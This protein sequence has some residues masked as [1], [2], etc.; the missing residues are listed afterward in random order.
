VESSD[1]NPAHRY[2]ER[3]KHSYESVRRGARRLD[4]TNQPV[5]YKEYPGIELEPLPPHLE[6]LLR[7]GA[8]VVR[9]RRGYEFRTYSS[10]GALYPI[11]VYVAT[12]DG[13]FHFDPRELGV[14]RLRDDD[15][16]ESL[17]GGETV[18][19]LTGILWRTAWKYDARGYRHLFWDAGTM[20]ANLLELAPADARVLTGFVDDEVNAVL[21]VDGEDE[22]ALALL[23]LQ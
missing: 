23:I 18:L 16:R 20:L 4:W 3:T 1:T 2:H 15:V 13:L 10:A 19:A 21:G 17:G 9:R 11:E 5:P 6:R 8:G 12:S 14:R 22:A 7:L